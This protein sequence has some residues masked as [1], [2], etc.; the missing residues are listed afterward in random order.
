MTISALKDPKQVLRLKRTALALGGAAVHTALCWVF[1]QWNFFRTTPQEFMLLFALF[2]AV[3]LL[4]PLA[5]IGG[6]NL[7]F[8]EPSLTLYQMSWATICIMISA[9]FVY[10]LRMVLLMFYLLVMIFG[11]FQLHLAGFMFIC[12]LAIVG[13]GSV[14]FALAE[15]Q[16]E[17]LNMRV[18]Y[19]QWLCFALVMASFSL[20]GADL[21]KLRRTS[22][23]QN[24]ELAQALGRIEKL[25]ITDEL[26]GAWNRRH[27]MRVLAG[28]KALAVRG[29]YNFTVCF[30]DLD[31]FKLVNDNYGHHVGDFVLQTVAATVNQ[32]LREV[33]FFA[34]FGGEEFLA[35]LAGTSLPMALAAAERMRQAVAEIDFEGTAD[36]LEVTIS[37]G[38]TDFQQGDT[39][40]DLLHRADEALY[41]AK[42]LG[43]NRV[44][45]APLA[46]DGS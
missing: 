9:Y 15:T 10:E 33:D 31:H 5:I 46:K 26:T 28:Q 8:K 22:R 36:G 7:H 39:V 14:L 38:A 19:I 29:D 23:R 27:I 30:M 40:D 11:A 43:R 6:F 32:E 44:V 16:V 41:E 34:R 3:H 1:L 18:E 42:R 12:A 13:Y 35:V 24:K 25:A 20:L 45:C 4:F 21:S 17:I 2:W 37:L